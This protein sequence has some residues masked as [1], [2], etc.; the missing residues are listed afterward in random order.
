MDREFLSQDSIDLT[1]KKSWKLDFV[2]YF[3]YFRQVFLT[4]YT[5]TSVTCHGI[6]D[7]DLK[8]FSLVS[9]VR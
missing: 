3:Q 6:S 9:P 1:K 5:S 4:F 2:N 7:K 8:N